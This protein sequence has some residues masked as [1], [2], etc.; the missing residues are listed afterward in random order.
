[1]TDYSRV[2]P[3]ELYEQLMQAPPMMGL[4]DAAK[5]LNLSVS[6][7]R[8]LLREGRIVGV[9]ASRGAERSTIPRL[10]V[11]AYWARRYHS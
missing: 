4:K 11:L 1:M 2:L 7:V 9:G 10:G 8:A 6:R 3:P 5:Y